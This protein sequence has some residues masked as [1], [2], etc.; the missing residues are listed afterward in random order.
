[1]PFPSEQRFLMDWCLQI[2][3]EIPGNVS[4][5]IIWPENSRDAN[6]HPLNKREVTIFNSYHQ[7]IDYSDFQIHL[8]DWTAGELYLAIEEL[9]IR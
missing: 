5:T 9:F 1:M 7:Q 4:N 2:S 3:F 6:Q 8:Y